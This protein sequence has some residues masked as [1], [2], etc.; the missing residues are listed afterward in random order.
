LS[1]PEIKLEPIYIEATR[2]P[3]RPNKFLAIQSHYKLIMLARTKADIW[4]LC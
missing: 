4:V 3:D 2:H 1:Q